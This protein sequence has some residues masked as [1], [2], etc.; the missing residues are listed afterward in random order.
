MKWKKLY[1]NYEIV[2]QIIFAEITSNSNEIKRE[3][4]SCY[5]MWFYFVH[6]TILV[7]M[8]LTF[9]PIS[10]FF[11]VHQAIEIQRRKFRPMSIWIIQFHSSQ[12]YLINKNNYCIM[13]WLKFESSMRRIKRK[14]MVFLQENFL[15]R[16]L[17][18]IENVF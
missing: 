3:I 6:F 12:L 4:F 16:R 7:P 15:S 11:F 1:S 10:N 14:Q 17:H 2:F 5:F 18:K 8:V 9:D 13:I